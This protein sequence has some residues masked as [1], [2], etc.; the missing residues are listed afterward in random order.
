MSSISP[1]SGSPVAGSVR[2][3]GLVAGVGGHRT[4]PLDLTVDGSGITALVGPS[5]V[6][7]T[8]VLRTLAGLLAPVDG[9]VEF[10][11]TAPTLCFQQAGLLRWRTALENVT[12]GLG[13]RAAPSD[14]D[15]ARSVLDRL[16]LGALVDRRPGALSGGQQ[17]RVAIAR[18]MLAARSVLLVDEP[19]A[20][21]DED[22][23]DLVVSA[24]RHLVDEGI[25]VGVAVHTEEEAGRIAETTVPVA[26][27]C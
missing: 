7:K 3:I 20:H 21:L 15:R 24:L 6:G 26:L 25:A 4:A 10:Q 13:R 19:F 9:T 17:R 14:V 18:S 8:T 11:P 16:D 1:N 27:P 2:A 12:F 22:T 5:G 23:G